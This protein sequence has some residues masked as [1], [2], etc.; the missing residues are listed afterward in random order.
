MPGTLGP[1]VTSEIPN[2]FVVHMR[3]KLQTAGAALDLMKLERGF[4]EPREFDY[5][6]QL[7]Y[8]SKESKNLDVFRAFALRNSDQKKCDQFERLD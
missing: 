3:M 8:V 1:L 7:Y 6:P 2:P 4:G 5:D